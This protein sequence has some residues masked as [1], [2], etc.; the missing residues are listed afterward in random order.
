MTG[1]EI[2]GRGGVRTYNSPV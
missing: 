2:V 1:A